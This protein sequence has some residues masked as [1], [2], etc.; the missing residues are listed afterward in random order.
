MRIPVLNSSCDTRVNYGIVKNLQQLW[1][2]QLWH[3]EFILIEPIAEQQ[4]ITIISA[5][6]I[7][8][9]GTLCFNASK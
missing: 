8:G 6:S 1:V 5:F 9:N 2:N 3:T 4:N 7:V